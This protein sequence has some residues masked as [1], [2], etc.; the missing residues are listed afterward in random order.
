M[1]S[2]IA[3]ALCLLAGAARAQDRAASAEEVASQ[4]AWEARRF[5]LLAH[6]GL[7]TPVGLVGVSAGYSVA[8]P[9]ILEAGVGTTGLTFATAAG[10]RMRLTLGDYLAIGLASGLA[11]GHLPRSCSWAFESRECDS[12]DA[13]PSGYF[14]AY[15]EA[16]SAQGFLS[17][18]YAGV[19]APLRA[20]VETAFLGVRTAGLVPYVGL[21]LGTTL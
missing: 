8:P 15:L 2:V 17:R 21:A 4:T 18:A 12:P 19:L 7:Y 5:S 16:R 13:V 9:W 3:G 10:T 20:D 14:D 11:Y 1:V 6:V